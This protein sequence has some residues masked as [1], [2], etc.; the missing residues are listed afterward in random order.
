ML[1]LFEKKRSLVL[2]ISNPAAIKGICLE[3]YSVAFDVDC[4]S[5]P[6]PTINFFTGYKFLCENLLAVRKSLLYS[7]LRKLRPWLFASGFTK[8]M[9]CVLLQPP[10]NQRTN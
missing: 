1:F 2:S 10:K 3:S 4:F 5:L 9:Y 7:D 8:D 6:Q